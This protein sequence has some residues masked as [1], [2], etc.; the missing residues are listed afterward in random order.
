M[1]RSPSFVYCTI[2]FYLFRFSSKGMTIL[3]RFGQTDASGCKK[4]ADAQSSASER[5]LP[6]ED[7]QHR[8]GDYHP[9]LEIAGSRHMWL[10]TCQAKPFPWNYFA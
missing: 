5:L 3:H 7:A 8:W 1:I 9:L 10:S 6:R 4:V 2:S